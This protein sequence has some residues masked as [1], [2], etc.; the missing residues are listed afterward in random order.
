LANYVRSGPCEDCGSRDAK[1]IYDDS[2]TFCFSCNKYHG[3]GL[4]D[5]LKPRRSNEKAV[6]VID[7]SQWQYSLP[8]VATDWLNKYQLT[9]EEM[10]GFR[11]NPALT[12]KLW[13]GNAGALAMSLW[14]NG[15]VVCVSYRLFDQ[16]KPKSITIGYRPYITISNIEADTVIVVEDYI[17]ALKVSRLYPCIPLLGSNMPDDAILRLSKGY[18][19]VY[20]WLDEDK[21]VQSMKMA[22]K[23]G[24][25]GMSVGTIYT[26]EDP[27][28]YET[29]ELQHIIG[30]RL[31]SNK[32]SSL[33]NDKVFGSNS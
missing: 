3:A 16:D 2:S 6:K 28:E 11:W 17:S 21:L 19:S 20:F 5:R 10:S 33:Y 32:S 13:D 18:R 26:E 7:T 29:E 15:R 23:A 12:S 14:E 8:G 22:T 4:K 25:L 27:K 24:L 30:N 9:K 1:A 31:N